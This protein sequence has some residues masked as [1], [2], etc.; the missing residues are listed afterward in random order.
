MLRLACCYATEAGLEI[1][2]GMRGCMAKAS[3]DVL[4]G[5]ELRTEATLVYH[6]DRYQ[7]PRGTEMWQQVMELIHAGEAAQQG[8][9]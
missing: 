3:R 9:A 1:G 4:A 7:D 6:L 8:A 2:A 5:F